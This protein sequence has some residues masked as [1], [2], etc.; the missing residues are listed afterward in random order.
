[1]AKPIGAACNLD[2][3]YCYYLSKKDLYPQAAPLR[4]SD[5]LLERFIVQRI[6]ASATESVLFSWHGG[7]PTL[8]GL[9]YFR[10]IVEL[11]Q[12]HRPPGRTILNGIQTN[13]TLLD[14]AWCRFLATHGFFVG[15][16]L[17]GPKELH[18]CYRIDKRERP[19]HEAVVQA[20]RRLQRYR[21]HC[22]VLCVVH[23]RNVREPAAVYRYFKDLGVR[24]LQFL[25][26]VEREGTRALGA[27]SVPAD[28]YGAFLCS[29]FDEWVR[30]DVDRVHIQNFDEATRP[31][32]GM[33][34]ALCISAPVCGNIVV[35]EHNGDVYACDHFVDT[36]HRIGN[37]A[38]TPL[39]ELLDSP[40]L[41]A[42]GLDKRERLPRYCRQCGVLALCN[43][44][45][46]KDRLATT[47][48]GE[49]GLNTLCAGL[50]RFYLHSRPTLQQL[51]RHRR[52]GAPAAEFMRRLRPQEAAFRLNRNDPCPCGS[53]R[54]YKKCCLAHA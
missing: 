22:D 9:D 54:K 20:L 27:H 44:G 37:I 18:D 30:H 40:A 46:P 32:L 7:E 2:C 5:A 38:V 6:A 26:L 36:E 35:L 25:P 52:S 17:D 41:R 16:S 19:S 53:G 47:P 51:A 45:C 12:Q 8:L 1:M 43:G 49:A 15:L 39:A 14:D 21:V 23:D 29:I 42:F 24:F 3:G 13:G 50:K 34:H 33:E 28:A 10:R 11:Q 4:M 31:F 48:E